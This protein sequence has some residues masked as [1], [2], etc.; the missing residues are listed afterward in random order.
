ML[1]GDVVDGEP[2]A[3]DHLCGIVELIG[4]GEMGDVAGVDHEGRLLRQRADLGDRLLKR[5]QRVRVG[6]LV[7]A[8]MAVA[9]LQ[10]G[11]GGGFRRLRLAEQAERFRHAAG[12]CPQNAGAR[13]DHAFEGVAAADAFGLAIVVSAHAILLRKRR[14]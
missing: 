5:R 6:R 1:A 3:A 12:D 13:P 7:E 14:P 10:E 8:D 11:E 9:D 4:L 2:G